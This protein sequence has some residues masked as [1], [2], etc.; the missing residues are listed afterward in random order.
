[1]N[2]ASTFKKC[3]LAAALLA[4]PALPATAVPFS[5]NSTDGPLALANPGTTLSTL[6]VDS[7]G[8]ITDLKVHMS[9]THPW[10]GDMR[11]SILH[12]ETGT[13]VRLK[14]DSF[15]GGQNIGPTTF[16]DDALLSINEGSAPFAG[17]FRPV[18]P[19]SAYFGESLGGTWTLTLVDTFLFDEGVLQSWGISGTATGLSVPDHAS[20]AA[21]LVTGLLACLAARRRI[22]QDRS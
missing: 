13:E 12:N 7:P 1:M 4:G 22:H 2:I 14:N 16:D 6:F 21:L 20:T 3:S 5:F 19:L 9:I 10:Q 8:I 11:I 18:E 15:T 17:S